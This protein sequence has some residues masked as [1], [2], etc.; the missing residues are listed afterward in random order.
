VSP[1]RVQGV[2]CSVGHTN[3]SSPNWVQGY[4]IPCQTSI[5]STSISRARKRPI[6]S[7]TRHLS[8]SSIRLGTPYAFHELYWVIEAEHDSHPPCSLD[9]YS[10]PNRSREHSS[11]TNP[12]CD[13]W[14]RQNF[15]YRIDRYVQTPWPPQDDANTVR[16]QFDRSRS[17][18]PERQQRESCHPQHHPS[19]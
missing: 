9:L 17:H 4:R 10:G 7:S 5:K 12:R 18:E 16:P 8:V 6:G 13:A 3:N 19:Q 14:C 2:V 11:Q 15:C 1:R